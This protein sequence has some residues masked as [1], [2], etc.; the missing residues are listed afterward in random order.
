MRLRVQ[1]GI[2]N[3]ATERFQMT[4]PHLL[5]PSAPVP[6]ETKEWTEM[7]RG[8]DRVRI[9][10][11]RPTDADMERTFIEELSPASRRFR[12][13]DSMATPSPMLLRQLTEI[14]ASTDVAYV[15]V[16]NNGVRDEEIGVG[17]FSAWPN[18]RDCEFALA[19]TDK[20]Q[21]KGLATHLMHH[22]LQAARKR[23]ISRMHSSDAGHNESMRRFA[24][25]LHMDHMTDPADDTQILYSI[26]VPAQKTTSA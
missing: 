25:H 15:A 12:F 13:L 9:R 2:F 19:V 14:D 11:I 4:S 6:S 7:L 8:G 5:Q 16:V 23:G 22:L 24:A 17:R 10:A 20:W 1:S 18:G 26:K 21:N 3:S